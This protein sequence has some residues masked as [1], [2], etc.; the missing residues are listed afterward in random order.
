MLMRSRGL[1]AVDPMRWRRP[2]AFGARL[3]ARPRYTCARRLDCHWLRLASTCTH[4][5][6]DRRHHS[7]SGHGHGHGHGHDHDHEDDHIDPENSISMRFARGESFT[8]IFLS[9]MTKKAGMR[10]GMVGLACAASGLNVLEPVLSTVCIL[11]AIG[12]RP[13]ISREVDE[14]T[15]GP[16]GVL[17][18]C[19]F[20]VV[21]ST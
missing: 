7:T 16:V 19:P 5:G 11:V 3:L 12:A 2:V 21:C 4:N 9:Q 13:T 6:L 14:E 15:K 1:R 18:Y 20:L 10:I 17:V 8:S